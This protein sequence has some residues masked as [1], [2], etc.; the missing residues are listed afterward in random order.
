MD[1]T[2]KLHY[3]V[4][5]RCERTAGRLGMERA[6]SVSA[7]PGEN[8]KVLRLRSA[9]LVKESKILP[10]SA[11]DDGLEKQAFRKYL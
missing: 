4:S 7:V 1:R 10:R 5:F 9:P 3:T 11:Q 8:H 6:N 2:P